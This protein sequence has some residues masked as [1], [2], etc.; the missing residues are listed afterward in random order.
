MLVGISA[1]TIFDVGLDHRLMAV[2]IRS[3][4]DGRQ[5]VLGAPTALFSTQIGGSVQGADRQQYMVSA[6]GQRFLMNTVLSEPTTPIVV[7]LNWRG[8]PNGSVSPP[9]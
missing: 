5:I 4:S 6:D 1:I 9:Q 7:V 8:A 2:P 3:A